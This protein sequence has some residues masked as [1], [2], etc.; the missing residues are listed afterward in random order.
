MNNNNILGNKIRL[1]NLF[2]CLISDYIY[3]INYFYSLY[4]KIFF[5]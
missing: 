2:L 4:I 5:N 3:K 1:Y